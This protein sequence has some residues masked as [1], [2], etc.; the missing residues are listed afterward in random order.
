[1]I[2]KANFNSKV[3]SPE[4]IREACREIRTQWSRQTRQA[5]RVQPPHRWQPPCVHLVTDR[6]DDDATANPYA[7]FC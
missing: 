3:P 7:E 5:R 6:D 1:M 4:E 2:A